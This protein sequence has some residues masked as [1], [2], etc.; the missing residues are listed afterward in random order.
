MPRKK[1]ATPRALK[2]KAGIPS[3]SESLASEPEVKGEIEDFDGRLVPSPR[4]YRTIALSFLG[5]T[6]L[7]VIFVILFTS[8]K[9]AISLTLKPQTVKADT[10]LAVA[11]K[12]GP[13]QMAGLVAGVSVKNEK[14]FSPSGGTEV[15][16]VASGQVVIYNKTKSNQPLVATTRLLSPEK[17]LFRLKNSVTVPAGGQITAAVYAD[18]PGAAGEIGPAK[19]TIPGLLEIKQ[20][21]I[22]AESQSRM[23]GG[24]RHLAAITSADLQRAEESLLDELQAAGASQLTKAAQTSSSIFSASVFTYRKGSFKTDAK[25]GAVVDSFKVSGEIETVAAFYNPADLRQLL[26][27]GLQENLAENQQLN[28]NAA[29]PAIQISQ[30]DLA[31][32]SAE[33]KVTQEFLVKAS[34]SDDLLDKTKILGQPKDAVLA[35]LKSL[36]WVDKAELKTRPSWLKKVPKEAGKV[37]IKVSE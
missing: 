12:A 20:K 9:A 27:T 34:Y 14:T 37:Q 26:L 8:G 19:F 1:S 24:V 16:A 36:P 31:A 10:K 6:V 18:K 33:L 17:V 35:Y 29:A 2:K 3:I 7:L 4:F 22:Y 5:I 11:G 25:V 30:Y 21:D 23:T 13:N 32:K 28:D 15:P